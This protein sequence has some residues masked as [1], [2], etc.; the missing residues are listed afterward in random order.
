MAA[1]VARFR[2]VAMGL[3][4]AALLPACARNEYEAPPPPEVT[5]A[6]PVER[7]VTTYREFTG[8]TVS[9]EAVDIRARVQGYLKSIHFAPGTDIMK[10]DLLFVIEPDLYEA[11]VRQ[12]EADLER[13]EARAKAAD[14]QLAITQAIFERKAG[15]KADLVEKT[16]A[17][18]ESRAAV[19]RARADLSAANLDLSYTRIY[20]PISGRIDRNYVDVGNLVGSGEASVLA[21]I[22]REQPIYAYF[23]VSERDL[24]EYTD[25]LRRG[26]DPGPEGRRTRVDLGLMTEEGFPHGGTLDYSSNRVDPSTG[27]IELRAVFPNT[28]GILIPGL[29]VR[30]RVPFSRGNALLVPDEAV[31]ADQGGRYVLVVDDS[32]VVQLV[33]VKPGVLTDGMRVIESGLAPHA[34]VVVNGLQRARPGSPVKP[35]LADAAREAATIEGTAAPAPKATLAEPSQAIE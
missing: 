1:V 6:P 28:R 18:D 19:A 20:A 30:L 4:A 7:E 16:Q 24:L 35:L 11:R 9:T 15:S 32:N 33:R 10:G 21:K 2:T 27:T 17:R 8:R 3:I 29:F 23:D 31:L 14:E 25:L 22:V 26:G 13:T 34:R 5:V 12:A